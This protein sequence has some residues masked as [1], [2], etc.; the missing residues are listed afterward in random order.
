MASR[1]G[2]RPKG[3]DGNDFKHRERIAD[4]YQESVAAK[5]S[6]KKSLIP[7]MFI[8]VL[9]FGRILSVSMG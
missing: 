4:H 6:I 5:V 2:A 3:S 1:T 8:T 7:H 9:G